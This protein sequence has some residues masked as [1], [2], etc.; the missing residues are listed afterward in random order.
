MSRPHLP[1]GTK[2]VRLSK[3]QDK[4]TGAYLEAATAVGVLRADST[5]T[6]VEGADN[7][8]ITKDPATS[9]PDTVYEGEIPA[10]VAQTPGAGYTLEVTAT[11]G[12]SLQIFSFGYISE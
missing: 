2:I 4:R 9:G 11:D 5:G 1:R 6:I 10:S 7:L 3:L 8:A 12:S